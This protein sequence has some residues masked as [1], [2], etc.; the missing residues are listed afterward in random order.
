MKK[1]R[2]SVTERRA[3]FLFPVFYEEWHDLVKLLNEES[4][5]QREKFVE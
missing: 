2:L 1:K 3:I 4:Q 5:I